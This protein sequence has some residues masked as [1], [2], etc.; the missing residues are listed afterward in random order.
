MNARHL[1]GLM[2][3]SAIAPVGA[4]QP[5][6]PQVAYAVSARIDGH[7]LAGAT[8]ALAVNQAAGDFNQQANL[9]AIAVG[10]TASAAV[11]PVQAQ[12]RN[13]GQSADTATAVIAGQALAG[14]AGIASINQAS[15]A[16]N[17]SFNAVS[18][19]LA[20]QGIRETDDDGLLSAVSAS[21]G[22]QHG[23]EHG[24]A[25]AG[26]RVAS[27]ESTAMQGFEGV[28]QLNQ[29]AGSGNDT[30]NSLSM[31]VQAHP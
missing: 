16:G 14:A 25:T 1:L 6:L 8:G 29:V 19:A 7:S 2:L 30:G 26:R 5:P 18:L 11:R 10:E 23:F 27:V 13:R 3:A 24:G 28:L 4:A 31:S 20:Q 9:R 12:W 22:Q 17:A 15:G 21:A